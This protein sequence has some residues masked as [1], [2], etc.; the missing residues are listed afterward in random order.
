MQAVQDNTTKR[1]CGVA[2]R[3]TSECDTTNHR[4]YRVTGESFDAAICNG[5]PLLVIARNRVFLSIL[6]GCMAMERLFVAFLVA[7]VGNH[8]P[9][10]AGE[11]QKLCTRTGVGC[12]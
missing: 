2:A 12:R 4:R 8:P 7:Q 10:V 1:W 11:V 9:K 3:T 6:H 5:E